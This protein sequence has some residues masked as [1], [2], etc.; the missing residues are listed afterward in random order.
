MKNRYPLL[1]LLA[2]ALTGCKH[3]DL[4][5]DNPCKHTPGY[6]EYDRYHPK[7]PSN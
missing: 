1:L 4:S 2:I 3:L 6:P 7:P 5:P